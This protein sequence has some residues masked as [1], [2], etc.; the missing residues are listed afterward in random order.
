MNQ[1]QVDSLHASSRKLAKAITK[2][3]DRVAIE[4]CKKL[5]DAVSEG[6]K[7]V[8]KDMETLD[9]QMEG[10]ANV[11]KELFEVLRSLEDAPEPIDLDAIESGAEEPDE[12]D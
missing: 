9:G 4:R 10:V 1:N 8:G 5:N 6:F 2:Q 7:H 11:L 3:T 12:Q